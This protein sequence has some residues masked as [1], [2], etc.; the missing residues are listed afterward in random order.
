MKLEN[1]ANEKAVVRKYDIGRFINEACSL[2]KSEKFKL[3]ENV[4]KS[5]E[6]FKFPTSEFTNQ[7]GVTKSYCCKWIWLKNRT[8]LTYSPSKDALFCLPC[9]L[10]GSLKKLNLASTG[11]KYWVSASSKLGD[12]ENKRHKEAVDK[13]H[14]FVK[15]MKDHS[16]GINVKM[17]RLET[18]Q[19]EEN[20]S[21][22][23]LLMKCVEFLGKFNISLRAKNE[24][25]KFY[26]NP[27]TGT[28]LEF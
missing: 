20:G 17:N 22:V 7:E 13:C 24:S 18:I 3:I 26:Q 12:H 28:Y 9:L 1:K 11:L 8:S 14:D 27:D 5:H 25:A 4:W 15:T 2:N 10:F 16:R 21:R 23:R 19:I 6:D